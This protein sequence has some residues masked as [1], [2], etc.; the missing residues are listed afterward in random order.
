MEFLN[1]SSMRQ[2]FGKI[3]RNISSLLF[4][5]LYVLIWMKRLIFQQRC[6]HKLLIVLVVGCALFQYNAFGRNKLHIDFEGQVTGYFYNN[7]GQLQYKEFYDSDSD[8]PDSPAETVEYTYDS[9]GRSITTIHP[10]TTQNPATCKTHSHC[11]NICMRT[12]IR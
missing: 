6:M 5:S 12:V 11:T 3:L 9:L 1:Q 10:A 8:Y 4:N 2:V 7:I